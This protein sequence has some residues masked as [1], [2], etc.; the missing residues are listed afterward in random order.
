[1]DNV[2]MIGGEARAPDILPVYDP[3]PLDAFMADLGPESAGVRTDLFEAF[4]DESTNRFVALV[5]AHQDAKGEV[6]VGIAHALRSASAALGLI[7]L[8]LTAA[9]IEIAFRKAPETVNVALESTR[10]I[11]EFQRATVAISALLIADRPKPPVPVGFPGT[12]PTVLLVED[13]P[14]SQRACAAVLKSSATT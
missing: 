5:T 13:D 7:A 14:V 3:A 10:L 8:S 6:L 4:L 2:E 11:N 9:D 12:V 1:V